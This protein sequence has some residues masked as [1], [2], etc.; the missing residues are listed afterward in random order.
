MYVTRRYFKKTFQGIESESELLLAF[1]SRHVSDNVRRDNNITL[2]SNNTEF[3]K[4][5]F[6]CEL[7]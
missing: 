4:Q 5:F 3:H 1:V 2:T 7:F 6:L